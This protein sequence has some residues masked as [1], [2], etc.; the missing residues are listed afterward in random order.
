[1][2]GSFT[3]LNLEPEAVVEMW[4]VA[5][6][7]KNINV[8]LISIFGVSASIFL[9]TLIPLGI[10]GIVDDWD[11]KQLL[12]LYGV[13]VLLVLSYEVSFFKESSLLTVCCITA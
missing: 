10:F 9:V 3:Q 12:I 2:Y 7:I 8:N 4:V 13:I 1:M 5:V 6:T 11:G